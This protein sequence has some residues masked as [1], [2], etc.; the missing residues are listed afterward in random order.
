MLLHRSVKLKSKTG[1]DRSIAHFYRNIDVFPYL[2]PAAVL[3]PSPLPIS[4]EACNSVFMGGSGKIKLSAR[5]HRSSWVAG[6]RC[7]V[8][9]S[10][11]NETSKKVRRYFVL[12]GDKIRDPCYL[13]EMSPPS[14]TDQVTQSQSDTH[15]QGL[16]TQVFTDVKSWTG[17]R[18]EP[19]RG[20]LFHCICDKED[21]GKQSRD[22]QEEHKGQR[23]G[24]RDLDG[25]RKRR[26][27]R[28]LPL[29][30]DTGK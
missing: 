18:R 12:S 17:R 28:V 23:N 10:V 6:T 15:A 9:V 11:L 4:A 19:G 1:G 30:A 27:R 25:G 5:L 2:S 21:R 22:G 13:T 26:A 24:E 29:F 8:E 3:K 7:Y 20:R 16:Q 14:P